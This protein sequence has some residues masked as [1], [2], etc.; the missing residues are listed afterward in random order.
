MILLLDNYDS[1]TFNLYQY[2]GEM[3]EEIQVFRNDKIS[4]S[5]IDKMA[6]DHIVLSPGPGR[7]DQ[8][9]IMI[10]LIK[11]FA[12]KIPIL[13]ICLGFQGIGEAFGGKV[14]HAPELFHGKTS[15]INHLGIGLYQDL[16]QHIEVARYHSLIV[17]KESLPD[18]FQI[19]SWT[20]DNL[21]M[22][23]RHH[24]Y[25][26]EGIQFHPESVLTRDGKT[27]LKNF[28]QR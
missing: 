16:P 19:T 23:I 6:P 12:A 3:G 13:G 25:P 5:D 24:K 4:L 8:A 21:I 28:I 1:F 7:P 20:R 11:K 9:G 14:V 17:E 15:E 27:M 18:C 2:L 22:G 26:L 10:D